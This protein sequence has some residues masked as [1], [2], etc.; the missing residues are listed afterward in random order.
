LN[1]L[2]LLALTAIF[3]F[4]SIISVVTG[5]TSLVTVP[6]MLQFGIDPRVAVATN[7]FALIFMSVGGTLP[8]L[9]TGTI[10]KRRLP[11][12]G[13][14]T[15]IGSI[16]GAWLLTVIA[17]KNIP[18]LVALFMI[19]IALF[20]LL[21]PQAG[22]LAAGPPTKN[23]EFAGY[24]AT[25]LLGIYGGFFSGGYVTLLTAVYVLCFRMTFLE[26]VATT[27]VINILSSIVA[28]V[29]FA[30][31]GLVDYQLGLILGAVMLIGGLIGARL[32]TKISNVWLR[33]IFLATVLILAALTMISFLP[34]F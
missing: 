13:M 7:M 21:N 12:L 5:S 4:T 10:D 2:T 18:L 15:L 24:A 34:S 33:R 8:F 16:A 19:A 6:A 32:A 26:A 9:R 14:L 29:I 17:A 23:A 11:L 3:L 30:R 20:S 22:V 25:L 31:S 28:T 1:T 27:K